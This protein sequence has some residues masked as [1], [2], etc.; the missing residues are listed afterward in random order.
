[1]RQVTIHEAEIHLS[2]LIQE[3]LAGEDVF[4]TQQNQPVVQLVAVPEYRQPCRIGGDEGVILFMADDFGAPLDDFMES[5][6]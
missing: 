3:V 5:T 4:I 1:M 6:P 2:R